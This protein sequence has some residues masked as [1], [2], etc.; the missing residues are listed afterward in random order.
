MVIVHAA[1]MSLSPVYFLP[2][3]KSAS[4]QMYSRN[5]GTWDDLRTLPIVV[6]TAVVLKART[7]RLD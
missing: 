5:D 4:L 1:D 3:L 2:A 7:S 6:V